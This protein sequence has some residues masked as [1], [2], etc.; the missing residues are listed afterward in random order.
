MRR[1]PAARRRCRWLPREPT[2][3]AHDG[4]GR[5]AG[6]A[7]R[8]LFAENW[9]AGDN[10]YYAKFWRNVVYW[11]SENS[12]NGRRRL[13]GSAAK[14]S[15]RPGETIGLRATV[16]DEAGNETTGCRL[17]AIVDPSF[18]GRELESDYA[19][20]CWPKG[21]VR[22]SGEQGPYVAWGEEFEMNRSAG[23]ARV[24]GRTASRRGAARRFR[25]PDV[26]HRTER[27]DDYALID[28]TPVEVQILDDPFEQQNP[29]PN[30]ELLRQIALISGGQVLHDSA[31]LAALLET[32]PAE[33]GPPVV[34][35]APAWSTWWLLSWLLLLLTVEWIWR[36]RLGMA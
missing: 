9:G 17:M 11:L 5:A 12:A 33:T 18:T 15:Y 19:P 10:R 13:I 14:L 35:R 21:V 8:T 30:H 36:R 23:W 25:H 24:R 4:S 26:A 28:S 22:E 31:S 3:R 20:I 7:V 6:A 1:R 27:Y 34:H 32:L 2:A 16:Y 29:L